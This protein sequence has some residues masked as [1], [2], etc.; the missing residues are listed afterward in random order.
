MLEEVE[1]WDYI[2]AFNLDGIRVFNLSL[3]GQ[4]I[5]NDMFEINQKRTA[6]IT[7]LVNSTYVNTVDLDFGDFL[8]V[9]CWSTNF[10]NLW[11]K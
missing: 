4:I 7:L 6:A 8:F 3:T 9:A 1:E 2:H 11:L 10:Y 5:F